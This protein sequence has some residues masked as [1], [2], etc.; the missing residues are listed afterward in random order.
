MKSTR[1]GRKTYVSQ[2]FDILQ[3]QPTDIRV[4]VNIIY[5]ESL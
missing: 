3:K 2:F 5:G 4:S 1:L